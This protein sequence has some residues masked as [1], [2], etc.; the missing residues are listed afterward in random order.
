MTGPGAFVLGSYVAAFA[1]GI[2]L[3]TFIQGVAVEG[4]AYAGG[5]FDWLTPFSVFTGAGARSQATRCS[6]PCFLIM[7]ARGRVAG[8][9]CSAPRYR[10]AQRFWRRSRWSAFG[11]HS[12]IRR[13]AARWFSWPNIALP[14]PGAAPGTAIALA[15]F[16]SLARG[17]AGHALHDGDACCSS[18]PI[19]ASRSASI[20]YIVPRAVTVWQAAARTKASRFLLVGTA[21]L[22]PI[23]LAYTGYSYWVFRGKVELGVGPITRVCRRGTAKRFA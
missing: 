18:S 14:V 11:R 22:L 4:R 1:Q 6:A 7:K 16:R 20:P 15:F 8:A 10:S 9:A 5:W 12:S 13:I 2:A 23:I 3:G 21:V 17:A 19:A